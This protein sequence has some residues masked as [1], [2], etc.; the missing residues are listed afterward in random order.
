MVFVKTTLT[1]SLVS[2]G[3]RAIQIDKLMSVLSNTLLISDLGDICP[4]GIG[5]DGLARLK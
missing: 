2:M 4:C 1:K 3:A 5:S